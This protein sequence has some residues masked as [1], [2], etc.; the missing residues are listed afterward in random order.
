[1]RHL[2]NLAIVTILALPAA[3]QSG[4]GGLRLKPID[5]AKPIPPLVDMSDLPSAVELEARAKTKDYLREL[6]ALR[7]QYFGDKRNPETRAKGLAQM[8]EFTDPA[9]FLPMIEVLREEKDDV[10]LALLDHF[11]M[12]GDW[13]QAALA[14]IAL[15]DMDA[16]FN[17][18]ALKRL[19]APV[20]RQALNVI[21]VGLRSENDFVANLA[22]RLA[23]QLDIIDAIPLLIQGQSTERPVRRVGDL[24]WILVGTQR[25][26]IQALIPILGEN[27][28]A[29][30]P[31]P[32]V[33][34]EGVILRV[35]DA[36]AIIYR[37]EI[38]YTLVAMTTRD[39]GHSTA[40]L[41]YDKDRWTAW[42]NHEYLPMKQEQARIKQLGEKK[43]EKMPG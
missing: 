27:S 33:L 20:S 21:D 29:F 42:Y 1:M 5:P 39:W 16:D 28:G 6:K 37:T 3:A 9:A 23:G 14:W 30:L 26:V 17:Y 41:G 38:H 7:H 24:A 19:K 36:V 11:V 8:R 32:G 15:Y 34:T 43:H 4:G 31:V 13:G 22:G 2:L 25:V 35:L 18:E 40:H 12:Q 10:R